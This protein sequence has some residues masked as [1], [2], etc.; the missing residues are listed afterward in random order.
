MGCL[1]LSEGMFY[2]GERRDPY[3]VLGKPEGKRPLGSILN[4]EDMRLRT[5]FVRLMLAAI[6]SFKCIS[7]SI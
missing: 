6:C 7:D 4:W 2:M 1:I 5:Q 3:T